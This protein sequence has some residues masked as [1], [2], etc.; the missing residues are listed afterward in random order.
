MIDFN[1]HKDDIFNNLIY[2]LQDAKTRFVINYGGAGSSKSYTQTQHELINCLSRKE[3]ILVI[4]KVSTTLKDSVISLFN[5]IAETWDIK[6]LYTEN[7]S[8]RHFNFVNGSEILFKGLDDPEKIK[9]VAG[10]T[11]VWIEEASELTTDDFK[12]LNLRLRGRNDLQM[13]LTF[14][15]I[16]DM[17]WIK[18]HFFDNPVMSEKTTIIKTTYKDNKFI[19][20]AYKD[21]LESYKDIDENYY[22]I[23]ALGEW[24][25]ITKGRIFDLWEQ[26]ETFPDIDGFWYG[27]DFG[28][29]NDP[30]SVIKVLPVK[31]RLYLDEVIYQ[32]GLNNNDIASLLKELGYNNEPIICDSAEPKS[33]DELKLNGINAIAADKG[34]GSIL[35]GIDNIKRQKVLVTKRSRNIIKENQFYQW[36]Q[37]RD[38]NY[39]NQP[40]DFMNHAIDAIR[41]SLS[42]QRERIETDESLFINY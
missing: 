23:Y 5:S 12:Q 11:R 13:T 14:N 29:S 20:Q 25:S 3:R 31:G 39:I 40:K 21:E 17:H 34:K 16:S 6:E 41:Y 33:I 27:L 7:K 8:D 32:T 30:T 35:E 19:D 4:R 36:K 15:P 1:T 22:N 28:Y 24:G 38:G 26:I 42:L 9:S 37:D 2:D 10:I 18:S